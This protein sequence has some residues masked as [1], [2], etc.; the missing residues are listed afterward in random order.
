MEEKTFN[1]LNRDFIE[2]FISKMSKEEKNE[3]KKF[4][5][6]NPRENSGQTFMIVK[7]YIYNTYF[8]KR[9]VPER[10]KNLFSDVLEELLSDIEENN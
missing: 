8:K 5:K 9:D 2:D 6:E 4:I 3:L 10:K 1:Q 7:S